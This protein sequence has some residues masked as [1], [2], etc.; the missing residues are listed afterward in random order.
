MYLVYKPA[1]GDEQRFQFSPEK[2]TSFEAESIE[3][4]TGLTWQEFGE[5]LQRN[6][7]I[8]MRALL[9]VLQ[10]RVHPT[11]KLRDVSF[12]M[13]EVDIEAEPH[14]LAAARE[15]VENDTTLSDEDRAAQLA[16]IDEQVAKIGAEHAVPKARGKNADS[17]TS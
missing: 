10:R 15:A 8:A 6:S 14:E 1:D 17:P 3:R 13:S 16:L 11:L 2:M 9:W 7:V 4:E 12:A 5:K